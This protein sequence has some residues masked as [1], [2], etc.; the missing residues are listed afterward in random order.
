MNPQYDYFL[1]IAGCLM[2]IF[3]YVL[4]QDFYKDDL[5]IRTWKI[6]YMLIVNTY[7]SYVNC[8]RSEN[9]IQLIYQY[10]YAI[11]YGRI[12]SNFKL[13]SFLPYF[14]S[15]YCKVKVRFLI[16]HNM[17]HI[18]K[19]KLANYN[20]PIEFDYPLALR[21][22]I[23]KWNIFLDYFFTYYCFWGTFLFLIGSS[24]YIPIF[25]S[26]TSGYHLPL[27]L[28]DQYIVYFLCY[29]LMRISLYTSISYYIQSFTTDRQYCRWRHILCTINNNLTRLIPIGQ[30][31]KND[32]YVQS[33][34]TIY[35]TT[36][37]RKI[38]LELKI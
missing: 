36:T 10:K 13:I 16:W 7:D 26:I 17:D 35:S 14:H 28:F 33:L 19:D 9:E 21:I 20:I 27:I 38:V 30:T 3:I 1:L 8:R 2:C 11:E 31:I 15:L 25:Y 23:I 6:F 29:T 37:L 34:H 18:H 32:S 4:I 24:M 22:R 12:M 5:D